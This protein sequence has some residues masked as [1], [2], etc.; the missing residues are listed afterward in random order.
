MYTYYDGLKVFVI[1]IDFRNHVISS[2]FPVI[3]YDSSMREESLDFYL[4]PVIS[5]QV[6]EWFPRRAAP[7]SNYYD[8]LR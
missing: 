2:W 3:L 5:R 7:R 1:S 8:D 6:V 4:F